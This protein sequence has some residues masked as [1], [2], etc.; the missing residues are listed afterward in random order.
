MHG[1]MKAGVWTLHARAVIPTVSSPNWAAMIMGAAPDFTGITSNDWQPDNYEIAPYCDDGSGHPPTIFGWIRKVRPAA[2]SALFTDW[3]DFERLI[4]PS[5]AGK[6]F[7]KDGD[8]SEVVDQAIRYIASERPVLTFI[9]V[10]HVDHAGHTA[11]WYT[12]EYFQAVQVADDLLGRLLKALDE[13]GLRPE[14]IVL[15]TADHG[16]HAKTHGA[17]IQQDI[18]IPW[19]ASGPGVPKDREI[20][21]PVST[22]QTTP[23]IAHWLG[24]APSDCWL[25]VPVTVDQF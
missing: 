9:H 14:T 11:G 25:A 23:T 10:D 15:V 20:R 13:S 3:P 12:P 2:H 18:E 1:L 22:T 24:L 6:V 7:V 8:A 5:A 16:G 19:I 17:M 4:E 21:R